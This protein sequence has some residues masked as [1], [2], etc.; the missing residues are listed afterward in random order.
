MTMEIIQIANLTKKYKR[1]K[2]QEGT[3]GSIKGLFSMMIVCIFTFIAFH[4]GNIY[5]QTQQGVALCKA[6]RLR[7]LHGVTIVAK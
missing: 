7:R 3:M 6:S 2:K 4:F 1:Y 5:E